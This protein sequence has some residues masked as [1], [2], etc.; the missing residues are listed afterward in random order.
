M[1]GEIITKEDYLNGKVAFHHIDRGKQN[2]NIGN[3]IFLLNTTHGFLTTAQ[4]FDEELDDF[5]IVLIKENLRDI[6]ISR[7]PL[8]WK[9]GWKIVAQKKESLF[10]HLDTKSP[11]ITKMY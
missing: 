7:I 2:D 8:S 9:I 5:F 10:L 3:L 4:R 6:L 1:T 11:N